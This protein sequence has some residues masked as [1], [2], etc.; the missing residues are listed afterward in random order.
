MAN[1]TIV[2]KL[3]VAAK[4]TDSYNRTFVSGESTQIDM[5]NGLI[6]YAGDRIVGDKQLY[7][8]AKP[9]TA[10]LT[11]KAWM[12]AS[13]IRVLSD[14]GDGNLVEGLTQ[15]PK[16]FTNKAGQTIDAFMPQV[17]DKITLT[18]DGITGTIGSNTFITATDADYKLNWASAAGNGLTFKLLGTSYVSIA[19]GFPSQRTATYEFECVKA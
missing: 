12:A 9:A 6:F 11:S 8:T 17:G 14:I 1:H 18:S 16:A 19:D 10:L 2:E 3:Q 4:N 15:N 5:D 7:K 13:P